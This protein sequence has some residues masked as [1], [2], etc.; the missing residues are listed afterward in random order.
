MLRTAHVV[1]FLLS[2]GSS[3]LS[4][5]Q[6]TTP[7]DL[8]TPTQRAQIGVDRM[9]S[10]QKT[11]LNDFLVE[12][13][14]NAYELGSSK[15]GASGSTSDAVAPQRAPSRSYIAGRGHWIQSNS[16]GK[17]ITLEDGSLWQI[18]I[19]DQLDTVLWLPVSTI[20]VMRDDHGVGDFTYVLVNKDD[21]K[22]AHAKFL[23]RE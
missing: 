18:D 22:K 4:Q 1:I 7:L 15:C 12:L 8:M 23:G 14:Q 16:N 17:I 3:L 11:A 10:A 20:T 6:P 13:V 19:I 21:G 2:A 5:V 9:T